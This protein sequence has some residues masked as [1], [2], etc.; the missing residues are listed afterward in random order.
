M[1]LP[2][3]RPRSARAHPPRGQPRARG[4]QAGRPVGARRARFVL[5]IVAD[6]LLAG[7]RHA[8]R[9]R[10]HRLDRPV[11]GAMPA[12]ERAQGGGPSPR[13]LVL[14]RAVRKRAL[15]PWSKWALPRQPP[16]SARSAS[17]RCAH[18]R[19]RGSATLDDRARPRRARAR[20]FRSAARGRRGPRATDGLQP[21]PLARRAHDH[22]ARAAADAARDD[23]SAAPQAVLEYERLEEDAPSGVVLVR[24]LAHTRRRSR[25]AAHR[26]ASSGC[27]SSAITSPRGAAAGARGGNTCPAGR[28]ARAARRAPA[29]GRTAVAARGDLRVTRALPADVDARRA[30]RILRARR[31]CCKRAWRGTRPLS[32]ARAKQNLI[33]R[34]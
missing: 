10:T 21:A 6:H 20:S 12:R 16:P 17:R 25:F 22:A 19:R 29:R 23:G 18:V 2:A 26:R 4:R 32:R 30:P 9:G 7:A 33:E 5:T 28:D 1:T 14:A 31:G 34:V 24:V 13:R 8:F 27:P 3:V 11:S 15:R